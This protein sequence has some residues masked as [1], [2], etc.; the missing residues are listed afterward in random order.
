MRPP[1]WACVAAGRPDQAGAA[2]AAGRQH[3]AR[4]RTSQERAGRPG[5]SAAGRR[6]SIRP[7]PIGGLRAR[8]RVS[9]QLPAAR[10]HV[11]RARTAGELGAQPSGQLLTRAIR[12][13]IRAA[14]RRARDR[15]Q[16]LNRLLALS[17]RLGPRESLAPGAHFASQTLCLPPPPLASAS[18]LAGRPSGRRLIEWPRAPTAAAPPNYCCCRCCIKFPSI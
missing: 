13:S 10:W 11:L 7:P 9:E 17:A 1:D 16:I 14:Q 8:E 12:P 6:P 2:A 5:G 3:L 4:G 15:E 18:R